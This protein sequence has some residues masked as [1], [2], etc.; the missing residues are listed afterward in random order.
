MGVDL[1]QRNDFT[2]VMTL[3]KFGDE[4]RLFSKH[5]LPEATVLAQENSHYQGWAHDEYLTVIDGNVIDYDVVLDDI[6]EIQKRHEIVALGYDKRFAHQFAIDL[7][8]HG[9]NAI[10]V[11]QTYTVLTG[12]MADFEGLVLAGKIRHDDDPITNWMMSN[13]VVKSLN[14]GGRQGMIPAKET[15][16][17]KIDAGSATINALAVCQTQGQEEATDWPLGIIANF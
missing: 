14:R 10:E 8:E 7:T 5:Y 17:N 11:P 16:A 6:L 9:I 13:I 3:F 4:Y 1:S 2:S 12:P 15:P